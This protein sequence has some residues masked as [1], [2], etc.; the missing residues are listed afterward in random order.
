[1]QADQVG[2]HC[3]TPPLPCVCPNIDANSS[4]GQKYGHG[5]DSCN[6][7]ERGSALWSDPVLRD[8]GHSQRTQSTIIYW[9]SP[10]QSISSSYRNLI[11][12]L[13]FDAG[14]SL[15]S[16]YFHVSFRPRVL[17]TRRFAT[18]SRDFDDQS[19]INRLRRSPVADMRVDVQFSPYQQ[20]NNHSHAVAVLLRR[21]QDLTATLFTRKE[22]E[23][24]S[25]RGTAR[26][27]VLLSYILHV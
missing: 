5:T 4:A 10:R 1:M 19:L 11:C 12:Q 13:S 23:L 3:T 2:F 20:K 21:W 27:R 26:R 18:A 22:N 7:S 8:C 16:W 25:C 6:W 15:V 14:G 17:N 24:S 9:T